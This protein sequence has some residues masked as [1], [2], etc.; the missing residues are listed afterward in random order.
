MEVG[1]IKTCSTCLSCGFIRHSHDVTVSSVYLSIAWAC[2]DLVNVARFA[3]ARV[4]APAE[5]IGLVATIC[6]TVA[7]SKLS[8]L[9]HGPQLHFR[10]AFKSTGA[11]TGFAVA[12]LC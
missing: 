8:A 10:R 4:P 2:D 6:E 1:A 11:V 3:G 12:V 7:S 5:L 9:S